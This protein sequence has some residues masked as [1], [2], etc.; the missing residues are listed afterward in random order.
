LKREGKG[1]AAVQAAA[2]G[3]GVPDR[4]WLERFHA[5]DRSLLEQCYNDHVQTVARAVGAVVAGVDRDT[6]VHDVFL[7]LITEERAR[8]GFRGGSFAVWIGTVARNLAIDHARRSGREQLV[9]P[10]EAARL[11]GGCWD[12]LEARTEA[13][14]L[15]ERFRSELLPPEWEGVFVARFVEQRS[16]RDAARVLGLG[17]TTLAWREMRIRRLLRKFFLGGGSR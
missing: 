16:Q 13:R 1:G 11:A 17:R 15:L 12:G 7:K 5:G 6:L 8:R 9:E 10:E 3:E 2:L 4:D 14:R